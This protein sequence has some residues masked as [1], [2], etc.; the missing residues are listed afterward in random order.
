MLV[1]VGRN[2]ACIHCKTFSTDQA[3]PNARAHNTLEHAPQDG[4]VAKPLVART[5]ER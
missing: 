1:G 5:R 2:Q 3:G 4:A